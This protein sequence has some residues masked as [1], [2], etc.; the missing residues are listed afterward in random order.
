LGEHFQGHPGVPVTGLFDHE[1]NMW[2]GATQG[3]DADHHR[4]DGRFKIE[5]IGLPPEIACTRLPGAGARWRSQMAEARNMAVFAVQLRAWAEG[6]VKERFFGTDIRFDPNAR[7]MMNLRRG[8]RF[9]AELL[10]A[11]G[12]RKVLPGIHGLPERIGPDQLSLLESAPDD[13]RCYSWIISHLFGTARMSM[14]ACDG[15]VAPDFSV[16]GTRRLYVLDSSLFPT[17]IGVNPQHAIMGI[18]MHAAQK[19]AQE[20]A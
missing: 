2:R 16:H 7:D 17:N 4:R 8:I 18:A 13:P 6:S 1:V 19:I 3:Y 20:P 14:R 5:T 11:A 10:F 9:S 12:A 15:V